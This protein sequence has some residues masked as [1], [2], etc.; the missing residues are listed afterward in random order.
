MI[1]PDGVADDFRREPIAIIARTMGFHAVSL[2][3]H[4]SN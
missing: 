2:A 4:G 3:V 1:K